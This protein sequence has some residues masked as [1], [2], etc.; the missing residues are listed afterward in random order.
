MEF[1]LDALGDVMLK[2]SNERV[3]LIATAMKAYHKRELQTAI[4]IQDDYKQAY[5]KSM[6]DLYEQLFDRVTNR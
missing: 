6:V 2:C 4:E 1:E 3:A 5:H